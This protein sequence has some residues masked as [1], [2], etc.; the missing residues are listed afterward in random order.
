[1]TTEAALVARMFGPRRR[2]RLLGRRS[3]LIDLAQF[4]ALSAILLWLAARG[5]ES[6]RYN[7]QWYRVPRYLYRI[8]DG[9]L[10]WGLLAQG[11]FVTLEISAWSMALALALGVA[12]ALMR[13]TASLSAQVL[14]R[15]YLEVVRNTPLLVQLYLL[16]FVIAPI[17][18]VDRFWTGVAC[19]GLYEGAFA[20]EVVRAGI[21][22]VQKGQWEAADSI[23]LTAADKYRF[24][25]FPQA[26]PLM[27]PPLTGVAVNLIKHSAIV[28]VIAVFDLT[29]Q[30]RNIIAD[31]FMSFEIWFTV[32]AVYLA[33]T[34]ALS[35]FVGWLEHR[36]QRG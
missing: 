36:V 30:G 10:I 16:Y 14:A 4:A 28:S 15:C 3:P 31:T 23:G 29:T 13:M 34:T 17:L 8:V 19:L 21:L 20:S 35:A 1:M 9:E 7:W 22:S 24:V 27:L 11:L 6:L 33:L 26:I 25:V 5:A 2:R 12:T 32:A 18:G